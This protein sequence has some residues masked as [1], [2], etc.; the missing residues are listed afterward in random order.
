MRVL[1]L[2][3]LLQLAQ[4]SS[5]FSF[6]DISCCCTINEDESSVKTTESVQTDTL[7]TSGKSDISPIEYGS[8]KVSKR[9]RI[10][11]RGRKGMKKR[12]KVRTVVWKEPKVEYASEWLSSLMEFPLCSDP[13]DTL[14]QSGNYIP[15][16]THSDALG[17]E[18]MCSQDCFRTVGNPL[19]KGGYG[20]V[21]KGYHTPT[22]STVALKLI[23]YERNDEHQMG[24]IRQEEC[25]Q[26]R[27]I[28]FKPVVQHYC[29]F[30]T[31]LQSK[32]YAVLVLEY[33]DGID[34]FDVIYVNPAKPT[35]WTEYGFEQVALWTGELIEM[36][37]ELHRRS[38]V[39]LDMKPEN[40][41]V[42]SRGHLRLIDF[43]MAGDPSIPC[44]HCLGTTLGTPMYAPPE[45]LSS[46]VDD[47]HFA[48][49]DW[50]CLGLTLYEIIYNEAAFEGRERDS[51]DETL[52]R[53][54]LEGPY[55]PDKTGFELVIDLAIR[56]T[57]KDP[58][59]RLGVS[60]DTPEI[61]DH[62]PFFLELA[63]I[64]AARSKSA[65]FK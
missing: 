36:V 25:L 55:F 2:Y 52:T 1:S 27:M 49:A 44:K 38:V 61:F 28:G 42:D 54:I 3:V 65:R 31:K 30:E 57:A 40:L 35:T 5:F 9:A 63:K 50:Y 22:K 15:A 39:L 45:F 12:Q 64:K 29:T 48:S 33:V 7:F 59:E 23:E 37:K 21:F 4:C 10:K 17:G 18:G 11:G 24:M 47:W 19:G 60:D 62:H 41:I 58:R 34:L 13:N 56:F 26:H 20:T 6:F 32:R 16:V 51:D 14:S 43:G 46:Y 53:A 8:M